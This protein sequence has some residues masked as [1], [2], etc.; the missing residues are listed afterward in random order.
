[1]MTYSSY[2]IAPGS[3]EP[4]RSRIIRPDQI[5]REALEAVSECFRTNDWSAIERNIGLTI[6]ST[7]DPDAVSIWTARA[8]IAVAMALRTP[9]DDA[10]RTWHQAV[11][12]MYRDA[13]MEPSADWMGLITD[14][15]A[16]IEAVIPE[17]TPHQHGVSGAL[18]M[19]WGWAILV[20]GVRCER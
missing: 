8:P 19:L 17:G 9:D 5:D 4:L 3:G 10:L 11:V 20:E 14:Y 18:I 15:P 12:G 16:T 13:G 7:R 1:M 2:L 6:R